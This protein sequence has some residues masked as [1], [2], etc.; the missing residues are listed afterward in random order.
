MIYALEIN[1]TTFP[2]ARLSNIGQLMNLLLPLVLAGAGLIFLVMLLK[3]AFDILSHGDNPDALK[4]AY[5]AIATSVIGLF[6]VI[7]SFV[8]VQLIGKIIGAQLIP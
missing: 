4:K 5:G 2:T 3:A 7:F 1:V 6:I 8:A